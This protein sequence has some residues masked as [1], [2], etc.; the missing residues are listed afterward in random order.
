[1]LRNGL[2]N[3]DIIFQEKHILLLLFKLLFKYVN[4][5]I[6]SLKFLFFITDQYWNRLEIEMEQWIGVKHHSSRITQE[7]NIM[8]T[9]E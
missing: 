2:E 1:M 7:E 5:T 6:V 9:C 4:L 8:Y 3:K